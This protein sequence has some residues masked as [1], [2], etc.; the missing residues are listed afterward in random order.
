MLQAHLGFRNF[1]YPLHLGILYPNPCIDNGIRT[2]RC[3]DFELLST[4][5]HTGHDYSKILAFS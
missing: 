2:P 4:Q 1:L 5:S 3:T